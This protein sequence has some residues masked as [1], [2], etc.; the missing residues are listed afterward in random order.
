MFRFA[1]ISFSLG[2]T[3]STA[4]VAQQL[5][6]SLLLEQTEFPDSVLSESEANLSSYNDSRLRSPENSKQTSNFTIRVK[7]FEF[8]GNTAFQDEEL[9]KIISHLLDKRI[10]FERLLQVEDIIANLYIAG[11]RSLDLNI[12]TERQQQ[13]REINPDRCYLNSGAVIT[14]D[15]EFE[16]DAAIVTV[17]V[18][19]GRVTDLNITID[20]RLNEN[21]IRDRLNRATQPPLDRTQLLEALQLLQLDPLIDRVSARLSQGVRPSEAVLDITLKVANTFNTRLFADNSRTPTVGTFRRGVELSENNLFGIGDRVNLVYT[22]TTGSYAADASYTLPLNSRNGTL[23]VAGGLTDTEVIEEPFDRLEILGSS[24]YFELSLNQPI[25]LNPSTELALGL[26]ASRQESESTLLGE[27]FPLSAGANDEGE[28]RISALRFFQN[29]TRRNR[30]DVL[31]LRSQFSFGFGAFNATVNNN[32]P[33][34]EFIA[35]QGQAQYVRSLAQDTLL[36]LRSDVQLANDELMPLEQFG[37]GGFRGV[38]GYRQ[39]SL[40]TDNGAIISAEV[41]I[42]VW[43]ISDIDGLLQVAPFVD[44]GIGWNSA[45]NPDPDPNTLI[46]F[47]LG[48]QWQMGDRLSL[49]LDWGIPLT[50]IAS[51]DETLQENGLYFSV[52]YT[53]F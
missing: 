19:E 29:F 42:P 9:A 51:N 53:A 44:F 40:L 10:G 31:A 7:R 35:W 41:Q 50:D 26:T 23:R 32:K 49:R 46:G 21:Y 12:D 2:L 45:G 11:C 30:R 47:G 25:I 18:I 4:S 22:N 3:I 43:R 13:L 24:R 8:V 15:Q 34:S 36:F 27:G 16:R 6:D 14:A 39:D 37:V 5:P 48:L 20:G 28:S 1:F 38:R 52:N 17:R 33:D